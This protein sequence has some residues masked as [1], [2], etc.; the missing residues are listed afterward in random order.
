MRE[1]LRKRNWTYFYE[2]PLYGQKIRHVYFRGRV[3]IHLGRLIVAIIARKQF[4]V[5]RRIGAEGIPYPTMVT[6]AVL[7]PL[8][9]DTGYH[10]KIMDRRFFPRGKINPGD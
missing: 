8:E 6:K 1:A 2:A 3:G 9:A 5:I 10:M 7:N 4:V